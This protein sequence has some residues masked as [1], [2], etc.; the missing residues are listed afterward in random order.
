MRA[1]A[2]SETILIVDDDHRTRKVI[3]KV[4]ER[5]DLKALEAENGRDGLQLL[6]DHHVSLVISDV[7]MPEFSGIEL[8]REIKSHTRRLP[9]ILM[10]GA[11]TI[12]MAVECMKLGAADYITKPFGL[13]EFEDTVLGTLASVRRGDVCHDETIMMQPCS[14]NFYGFE[15]IRTLGEG[16][17]G[18]VF[19]VKRPGDPRE[20]ALKLFKNWSSCGS[21]LTEMQQRFEQEAKAAAQIDHPN[22]VKLVDY[23]LERSFEDN[24]ILME[25]VDGMPLDQLCNAQSMTYLSKTQILSQL[26][27]ALDTIH[28]RNICHRDIKP[29]N[30]LVSSDLSPKIT[31]FGIARLPDSAITK[32]T[33]LVGSPRYMAPEAFSSSSV[34]NRADIFSLGVV[35]YE[36]L[37][38]RHPFN[39]STLYELAMVIRSEALTLPRDIDAA[40]PASLETVLRRMLERAPADRYPTAGE[41]CRDLETCIFELSA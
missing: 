3:R 11:G 26:A 25:Y 18:I 23:R 27:D 41:V 40:F 22:I 39:A 15:I 34:D 38:N 35:A 17:M 1:A 10:T 21:S 13:K 30:I 37:L 6:K 31:D 2:T 20:Y 16:N 12:D 28:T 7:R 33:D 14:G 24:Y 4:L 8:L 36:F 9:V 29:A 5:H 32:T 19:L